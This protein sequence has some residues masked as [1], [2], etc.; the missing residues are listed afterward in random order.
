MKILTYDDLKP[1]KGIAYSKVSLWRLEKRASFRSA[2][3]WDV[4]ATAG[5]SMRLM[6]GSP[7]QIRVRDADHAAA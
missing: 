2:F 5:P 4:A 6:H 1:A 3:R 7:E